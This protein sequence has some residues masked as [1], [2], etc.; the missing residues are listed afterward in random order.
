MKTKQNKRKT[1][2]TNKTGKSLTLAVTSIVLALIGFDVSCA[3]YSE[4]LSRRDG[5]VFTPLFE[6]LTVSD[7]IHYGTF[8]ELC[9]RV[10]N[11]DGNV[12]HRVENLILGAK[13]NIKSN[14]DEKKHDAGKNRGHIRPKILFIDEI[15]VSMCIVLDVVACA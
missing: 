11:E 9:E 1:P 12:R 14:D 3:C 15:G 13:N 7:N 6:S 4:Y 5:D 10:I 8:D 2:N